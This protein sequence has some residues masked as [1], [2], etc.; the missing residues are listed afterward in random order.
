MLKIW[1]RCNLNDPKCNCINIY[2]SI[3]EH[4]IEIGVLLEIEEFIANYI[5]LKKIEMC[6]EGCKTIFNAYMRAKGKVLNTIY[7]LAICF[8]NNCW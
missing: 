2:K 3:K 5:S 8:K 1:T 6:V 4:N 7:A